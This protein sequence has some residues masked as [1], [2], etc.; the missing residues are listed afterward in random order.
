M[1]NLYVLKCD[2]Q[3]ETYITTSRTAYR[4]SPG[5]RFEWLYPSHLILFF[6][7]Q[8]T[9]VWFFSRKMSH[10]TQSMACFFWGFFLIMK[11]LTRTYFHLDSGQLIFSEAT[12]VLTAHLLRSLK[13]MPWKWSKRSILVKRSKHQPT[14]YKHSYLVIID[15][16]ISN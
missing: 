12:L 10:T 15:F 16:N 9:H 1:E 14:M 8:L 7:F 3:N 13:G 2:T 11:P 4:K 5:I 6:H